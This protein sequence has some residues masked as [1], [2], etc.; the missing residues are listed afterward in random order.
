MY[1]W[2]GNKIQQYN[3]RFGRPRFNIKTFQ[4]F[5]YIEYR[6]RRIGSEIFSAQIQNC[7]FHALFWIIQ[8]F[9][10]FHFLARRC[11]STDFRQ[12][13]VPRGRRCRG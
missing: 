7:M 1:A 9:R 5:F 6:M 10:S 12:Y 3:S 2:T 11:Y 8:H 4:P 13:R